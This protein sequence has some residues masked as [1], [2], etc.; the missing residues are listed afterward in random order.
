MDLEHANGELFDALAKFRT[1]VV[2]PVKSAD[3]PFF[4]SK[5][6]DLDG[7]V[8]SVD[9][10]CEGTGLGWFQE[11]QAG[12][13]VVEVKTVITHSNG[14]YLVLGPV[15]MPVGGKKDAQAVGS[16][17]TY[18]K[19]YALAAAFGI[20]SDVDD[21]ANA[22]QPASAPKRQSK[23]RNQ[24]AASNMAAKA[25]QDL[26]AQLRTNFKTALMEYCKNNNTPTNEA[27]RAAEQEMLVQNGAE[28]LATATNEQLSDAIATVKAINAAIKDS[29]PK[30]PVDSDGNPV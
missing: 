20:S 24:S 30:T 22:N 11:V 12:E 15:S 14:G 29:R 27:Y 5:Y 8:K 19:R 2:Q 16:A 6:V 4:K 17:T 26:T 28:S 21:D 7:V 23:P 3:N 9:N 18:A 1:Q 10:G 13:N 25:K